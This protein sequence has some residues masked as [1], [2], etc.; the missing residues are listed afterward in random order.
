VEGTEFPRVLIGADGSVTVPVVLVKKGGQRVLFLNFG[1]LSRAKQFL[2]ERIL[3]GEAGVS[4]KMF[5]AESAYLDDLRAM[6][7]EETL[8]KTFPMRPIVV[9]VKMA[10]DQ[11]GLRGPQIDDLRIAITPGS[12]AE[13]W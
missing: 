2:A 11:Y 12:G 7:V 10:P 9:D 5:T 3:Q 8:A 13:G 6:A 1:D 4:I